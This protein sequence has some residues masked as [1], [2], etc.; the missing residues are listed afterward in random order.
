MA[1]RYDLV[2]VGA[3]PAGLMAAKVAGENG[4]KTALIER[5]K[6]IS[7]TRRTDGGALGLKSYLFKQML[8]YNPRDKRFCFPTSGFSLSYD[9]PI[10]SL[11]GFRVCSPG[12]NYITFGDWKELRK[13]PEKN[14]VGVAL[15]KGLLLKGILDEIE[16]KQDVDV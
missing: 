2:V 3:G 15:D 9:G 11:Y 4:I 13:D 12:G 5:R 14:R 8:T 10:K 1:K 7:I 6:D 16:K